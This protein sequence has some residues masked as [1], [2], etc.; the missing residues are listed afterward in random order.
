MKKDKKD[1]IAFFYEVRSR[2]GD[3]TNVTSIN[4]QITEQLQR[5]Q[6]DTLDIRRIYRFLD[7]NVK[8]DD[9]YVEEDEEG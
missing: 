2:Y 7:K 8:K 6:I 1:L 5:Y 3:L 4:I 9:D